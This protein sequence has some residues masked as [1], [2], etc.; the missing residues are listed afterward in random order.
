[1]C[2]C[3][4]GRTKGRK[5]EAARRAHNE[6]STDPAA[7]SARKSYSTILSWLIWSC[8]SAVSSLVQLLLVHL[9]QPLM[10]K[11]APGGSIAAGLWIQSMSNVLIM[12]LRM[13][14]MLGR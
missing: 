6:V 11:Q 14:F 8:E 3:D 1:M 13:F 12:M 9:S 10:Q 5:P 4:S 7:S 2:S